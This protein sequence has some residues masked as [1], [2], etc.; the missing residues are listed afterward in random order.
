MEIV[1]LYHENPEIRKEFEIC[2]KKYCDA[3]KMLDGALQ[4]MHRVG[5]FPSPP[6]AVR[7]RLQDERVG[8]AHT[9]RL[10]AGE[11]A[12]KMYIHT[13]TFSDKR[14]GELFLKASKEGSFVSGIMDAFAAVFSVALQYGVPL[15]RL[16]D[17]FKH[18]R[19]EPAGM[20][21][22]PVNNASSAV[23]YVARWLELRYT[24]KEESVSHE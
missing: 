4:K 12:I 21:S 23:D 5:L 20:L 22:G 2:M 9:F 6:E 13:G 19:F 3:Q 24:K 14:V 8:M 15:E 1:E 10:G 7:F 16:V 17:K 11:S 18:T